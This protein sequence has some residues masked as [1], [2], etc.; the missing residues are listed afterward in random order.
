MELSDEEYS[1]S[2]DTDE[3]E[4]DEFKYDHVLGPFMQNL[5]WVGSVYF[6]ML[7][8]SGTLCCG[9]YFYI[10][11]RIKNKEIM[12]YKEESARL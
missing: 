5:G 3:S 10:Y 9:Y 12:R 6:R 8:A 2:E 7:L 4:T 11:Q 1:L